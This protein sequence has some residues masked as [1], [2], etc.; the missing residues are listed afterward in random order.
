MARRFRAVVRLQVDRNIPPAIVKILTEELG[1][2]ERAVYRVDGPLDLSRLRQ[3]YA[4][5]RPDLKDKPFSPY[6]PAGAATAGRRK[7]SSP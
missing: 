7:T 1:W 5:D 4:L 6:T 2:S 3:L